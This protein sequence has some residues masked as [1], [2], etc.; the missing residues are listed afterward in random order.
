MVQED[1]VCAWLQDEVLQRVISP[2]RA[3]GHNTKASKAY[4]VPA[5]ATQGSS[6]EEEEI[7]DDDM[8]SSEEDSAG[9]PLTLRTVKCYINAIAELHC[10][11]VSDGSNP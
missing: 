4:T 8:S 9:K 6:D 2:R 10:W 3:R 1:K 5:G 11:Q 7:K